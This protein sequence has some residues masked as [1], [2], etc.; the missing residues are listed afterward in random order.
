ML[1]G[2]FYDLAWRQ[3]SAVLL[4]SD[5]MGHGLDAALITMLV[6]GAFQEAAAGTG[7]PAELLTEMHVRLRRVVPAQVFVAAAVVRLP[8]GD[9]DV[10]LANAGLPHP[11]VL[12]ASGQV[13]ELALAGLPLG[14]FDSRSTRAHD[15]C[16]A[17]LGAGDVLL[18]ASDGIGSIRCEDGRTFAERH[19]RSALNTLAG[20]NGRHV[21]DRLAAEAVTCAHGRPLG[22]DINLM[23][24]S[25]NGS[26]PGQRDA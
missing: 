12:R 24:V 2:D 14:L 21:I 23:A 1:G 19:L 22:D 11:F 4:V 16:R 26:G 25:R 18:V 17:R 13:E 20:Q 7:E 5:V 9:G 3:D 10:E 15:A 8:L 6:K